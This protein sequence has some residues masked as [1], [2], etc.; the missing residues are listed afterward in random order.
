MLEMDNFSKKIPGKKVFFLLRATKGISGL[1]VAL[2][3]FS[4]HFRVCRALSGFSG[5]FGLLW[6]SFELAGALSSLLGGFF[7]L[8]EALQGS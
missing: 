2:L 8:F 7:G 5:L 3:G 6:G 4:G 1:L